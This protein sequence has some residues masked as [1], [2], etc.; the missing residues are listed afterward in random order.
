MTW[1]ALSGRPCVEA[2]LDESA[3]EEDSSGEWEVLPFK[4]GQEE[5]DLTGGACQVLLATSFD[6][7]EPTRHVIQRIWLKKRAFRMRWMTWRA[8]HPTHIDS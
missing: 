5:C 1:R 4:R 7:F 3:A 6:A 2:W 8:G